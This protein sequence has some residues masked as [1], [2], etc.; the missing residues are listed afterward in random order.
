MP[1]NSISHCKF[2]NR[3]SSRQFGYSRVKVIKVAFF[4]ENIDFLS[5]FVRW[6][7]FG[8]TK[9]MGGG[10][11][12]VG[13]LNE[14]LRPFFHI[15]SPLFYRGNIGQ[16]S[17]WRKGGGEGELSLNRSWYNQKITYWSRNTDINYITQPGFLTYERCYFPCGKSTQFNRNSCGRFRHGLRP[18]K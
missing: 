9:G 17:A 14:A 10:G 1:E 8:R 15:L 18:E 2:Q 6:Y 12:F 5:R 13:A 11:D 7:T 3:R 4:N 16:V